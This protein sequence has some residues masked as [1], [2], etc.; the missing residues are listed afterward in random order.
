[1]KKTKIKL[2]E[3][4]TTMYDIKKN[5]LGEMNSRIDTTEEIIGELKDI[6][7]ETTQNRTQRITTTKA[8][9]FF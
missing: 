9:F 3:M 8:F 1:M 6:D 2:L 7:T 5:M 4:K